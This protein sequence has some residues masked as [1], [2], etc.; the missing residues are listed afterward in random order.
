MQPLFYSGD[1]LRLRFPVHKVVQKHTS[2]ARWE[3]VN[4]ILTDFALGNISTENIRIRVGRRC[5]FQWVG[6]VALWL[7]E[8]AHVGPGWYMDG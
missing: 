8:L 5:C 4:Y 2:Y 3:N 7:A 6:D 1:R